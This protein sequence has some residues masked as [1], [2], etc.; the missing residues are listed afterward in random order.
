ML[1]QMPARIWRLS[2]IAVL[3][4][5]TAGSVRAQEP[6]PR[7]RTEVRVFVPFG[8]GG[9]STELAPERDVEGSCDGPSLASTGRPDAWRCMSGNDILDPCFLQMMGDGT[10]VAC[11]ESPWNLSVTRLTAASPLPMSDI[12]LDVRSALPWAMEL[13][14]GKQCTALTGATFGLVG[15]RANY[16][17]AGGGLIFGEPDRS[18]D[19]WRAFYYA[20]DG[21][22]I[23]EQV[24]VLTAWY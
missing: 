11:L 13:A 21:G 22:Y 5:L 18:G 6:P 24:D 1:A 12:T 2:W 8:P 4:L 20:E 9:L 19:V 23:L 14:N 10:V 17:C 16:G 15:L 7:P 3:L